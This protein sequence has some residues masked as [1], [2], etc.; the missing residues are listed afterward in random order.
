M[1]GALLAERLVSAVAPHVAPAY[2]GTMRAN[3]VL[4]TAILLMGCHDDAPQGPLSEV[5]GTAGPHRLLALPPDEA[6]TAVSATRID[7]RLYFKVGTG[8]PVLG[9]SGPYARYTAVHSTGLCGE[10]PLFI[11]EGLWSL[12]TNSQLPGLL[13][14]CTGS[15]S[16]DLV[17]VDPTGAT[18]PTPLLAG[19]CDGRFTDHGLLR[20]YVPF[21]DVVEVPRLQLFPYPIG[22]GDEPVE[23]IKADISGVVFFDDELL[24]LDPDGDVIRVSL[25]RG[26]RTIE[27]PNVRRFAA[28]EDGRFL[29]WLDRTLTAGD[30][31]HAAGMVIVR[32][33]IEGR[34]TVIAASAYSDSAPL[35]RNDLITIQLDDGRQRLV[36]LPSLAVLDLPV[37]RTWLSKVDDGRYLGRSTSGDEWSLLDIVAGTT[38][39]LADDVG[40]ASVGSDALYLTLTDLTADA[41][42]EGPL[43]R[44]PF[45]GD[46]P[47]QIAERVS[48]RYQRLADGRLV[49]PLDL[50]DTWLG[51]LVLVDPATVVEHI[52]DERV[53]AT[54]GVASGGFEPNDV[55]YVVSDGE[56]SGVWL[57]RLT[58]Q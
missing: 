46:T 51:D 12:F 7:E 24:A 16:G 5:C 18:P 40:V 9:N 33:R 21:G 14:G 39:R 58:P 6:V 13:L 49:T 28:S 20:F 11:G 8:E 19:G 47:K 23:L 41:R 3:G 32:D 2:H 25:P 31:E 26:E 52:V 43:W 37:A 17:V 48:G 22:P 42:S 4:V 29:V 10:D 30:E 44:Y 55:V 56:R 35:L 38:T 27:Q 1:V 36:V 57:A 53:F 34:E 54:F 50:D 15:P 45:D